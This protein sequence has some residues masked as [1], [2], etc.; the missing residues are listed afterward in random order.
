[1]LQRLASERDEARREDFKASLRNN[2][3]SD[4]SELVILDETM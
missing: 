4:G 2:F 3:V 1:V